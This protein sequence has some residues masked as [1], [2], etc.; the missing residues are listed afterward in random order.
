MHAGH[1]QL[2]HAAA[3]QRLL[4]RTGTRTVRAIVASIDSRLDVDT[5]DNHEDARRLELNDIGEVTLKL[6]EPVAFDGYERV[7]ATGSFLLIDDQSG[8]TVAAGQVRQAG[9]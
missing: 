3:R 2:D 7:R 9:R 1:F 5:L 6:A 4:L 8:A